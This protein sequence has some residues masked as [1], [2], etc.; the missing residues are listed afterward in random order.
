LSPLLAFSTSSPSRSGPRAVPR[1]GVG[2]GAGGV[3]RGEEERKGAPWG[4]GKG[5]RVRGK[6]E[7]HS[8]GDEDGDGSRGGGDGI[9]VRSFF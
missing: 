5:A 9:R 8:S 1:E 4:K 7:A 2:R 3:F 6:E